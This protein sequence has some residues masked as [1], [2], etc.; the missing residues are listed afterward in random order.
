MLTRVGVILKPCRMAHEHTGHATVVVSM[1]QKLVMDFDSEST[2]LLRPLLCLID[3][4][5][6]HYDTKYATISSTISIRSH[7]HSSISS[8]QFPTIGF[9]KDQSLASCPPC[10]NGLFLSKNATVKTTPQK[11]AL[12]AKHT[13]KSWVNIRLN[14]VICISNISYSINQVLYTHIVMGELDHIS[15]LEM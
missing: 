8:A 12:E 6:I 9:W 10:S 11:N 1:I 14:D 13:Q 3:V 4:M 15:P 2:P 5:L 7:H